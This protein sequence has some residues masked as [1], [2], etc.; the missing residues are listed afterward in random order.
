MAWTRRPQDDFAS[1]IESHLAIETQRLIDQGA[2]PDEAAL[3]ARKAFGSVAAAGERFYESQRWLC[4][5]QLRQDLRGAWRSVARYPLTAAVAMASLAAGIGATTM[6]L[7]VRDVIFHK[8]PPTYGHPQ[9]LSRVQLGRPD[10]PV[11]PIGGYVPGELFAVWRELAGSDIAAATAPNGLKDVRTAD[12]TDTVPI[13]SATPGFFSVLEVTPVLGVTFAPAATPTSGT[14]PAVLSYRVWRRLFD[15]RADVVGRELWIENRPYTVAG[16]LPERFWFSEMNAPI[17]IALD[18][19]AL[20][21]EERLDM[22]ARRPAG[23]GHEALAAQLQS[24]LRAYARSR[25]AAERDMRLKVSS[26]EGTPM[27]AAMS[28]LLP[29]VLAASVLLTLVIACANVAILMIAQ[30]TSREHEIAL[31]A[32]LGASRGRIVRALLTE[33]TLLAVCGGALGVLATFVLRGVIIH[34]TRGNAGFFD[35]SVDPGV[36]LQAAAV[37]LLSGI[38]VGLAPALYETRRLH[39]N[40]LTT[41]ATSDRVRQRWRHALVILEITVTIALLVETGSMI[42]AYQRTVAGEMGFDRRPL[43]S[44]RIENPGGIAPEQL[45]SAAA[46]IPGVAAAA[47][48]TDVPLTQYGREQRVAAD[49]GGSNAVS[50]RTAAITPPFFSVLDVPMRS[51]RA[52]TSQDSATGRTA[53]VN[54]ALA[55]QL[56]PGRTAVGERVWVARVSYDIVGVVADYSDYW[57]ELGHAAPKL[58]LPLAP[59]AALKRLPILVR[60]ARDAASIKQS[61]RRELRDAAAGNVV[62]GMFTFDEITMVA[63]QEMLVGTA[64]LVPLIAIG[65]M[66]TMAGVYGVLAFAIARRSRELAIRVAVGASSG[67]LIRL[68]T[69]HSARLLAMGTIAGVGLTFGLARIVR[70]NGGAGSIYDPPWPAFVVPILIVAIIG[71]LATWIP[72]RRAL[73]INPATLLRST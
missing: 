40:P 2:S 54:E 37:T 5:D 43:V 17:W 10:R 73:N 71:A 59:D 15:A 25:P 47:A 68:V 30:W 53:I 1:E 24:G 58:F 57:L 33:S 61:L 65:M 31:R 21:A 51:G 46:R 70:S 19:N 16:V 13:R 8:P 45:A 12:R 63:G 3:S 56:F 35:L 20:A 69:A 67:D 34:R 38:A 49:A 9:Q 72:S 64:P 11:T 32:S 41:L 18:P 66:L 29:Y 52:F 14:R 39:A 48:S 36:L 62:T 26:I 28:L 4:W 42:G 22:V 7:I 50:A 6:T 44:A 27:G 55:S 23:V 60:A